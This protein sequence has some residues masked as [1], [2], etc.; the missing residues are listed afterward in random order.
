MTSSDLYSNPQK[1]KKKKKRNEVS[2]KKTM[3]SSISYQTL[4]HAFWEHT[5]SLGD[6][7]V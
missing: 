3:F 5:Y 2:L 6:S 4:P 7:Y 1:K